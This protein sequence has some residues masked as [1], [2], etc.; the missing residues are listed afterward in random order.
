MCCDIKYRFGPLILLKIQVIVRFYLLQERQNFHGLSLVRPQRLW[1]PMHCKANVPGRSPFAF[2]PYWHSQESRSTSAAI[3]CVRIDMIPWK[4]KFAVFF[5]YNEHWEN[6]AK[7]ISLRPPDRVM[8]ICI[9]C[10]NRSPCERDPLLA[11]EDLGK[12]V[13]CMAWLASKPPPPMGHILLLPPLT[14]STIESEQKPNCTLPTWYTRHLT[15]FSIDWPDGFNSQ[16]PPFPSSHTLNY[17][18]WKK[19]WLHHCPNPGLPDFNLWYTW[20]LS[21]L[22]HLCFIEAWKVHQ[23]MRTFATK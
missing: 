20:Y 10:C 17:F 7:G 4:W 3:I 14:L 1:W 9:L 11:D 8:N 21:F 22:V 23:I 18:E 16:S 19:T 15:K 5:R 12:K 6:R 2:M 13:P